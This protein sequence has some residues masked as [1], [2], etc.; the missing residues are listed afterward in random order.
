MNTKLTLFRNPNIRDELITSF[1]SVFDKFF[2]DAFPNISSEFG[3]NAFTDSSYP[4]VDVIDTNDSIVIE[5]A[6][7]GLEKQDV[8]VEVTPDDKILT[9]SGIK[10]VREQKAET[11]Y[12]RRELK[13]SA[14]TR[15]FALSENLDT[16]NID[17]KFENGILTI[18]IAKRTVLPA[19]TKRIE[20]K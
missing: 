19:K 15:S 8:T 6:V 3:A 20:L 11:T 14:F 12:I 1:D 9:I 5:A 18:T 7:P 17:A 16:T 2:Q 10:K 4:K 13:R